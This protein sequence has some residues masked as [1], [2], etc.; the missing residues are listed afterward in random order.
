MSEFLLVS[1]T[2]NG[3]MDRYGQQLARRIGLPTLELPLDRTSAGH[4]NVGLLSRRSL[5]GIASDRVFVRRLRNGSAIPH[6]THHHLARYGPALGRPFLVTA[7]D[8]IR[9]TDLTGADVLINRPNLRDRRYLRRDYE[10]MRAATAVIAV[11]ESTRRDLLDRLS[12]EPARVF[13][14]HE[15]IDHDRFRP[16]RRRLID[17]PYVLFVGSEH[18]RKNLVTLLGAFARLKRDCRWD[19]LGLVKLGAAGSDEAP[20]RTPTLS[21]VRALGLESE[22]HF[23][24]EVSDEDLPAYYSGAACLVLPSRAEGFGFPPLEAMACGCPVVVSTAGALP[25]IVENAGL[26]VAPDD[27]EGLRLAIQ[28]LLEDRALR[29]TLRDRGLRRAQAFSWEATAR[30]TQRVYET[31]PA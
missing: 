25:E 3:S 12:L 18:P 28:A 23:T 20:F 13:V 4:F 15:G 16:V 11:S 27:V 26:Q 5:L 19:R 10:G 1:T 21:A 2:G 22:V 8:L 14:V 31:V 6:F 29:T 9:H 24:E 17:E 7:H 30:Q